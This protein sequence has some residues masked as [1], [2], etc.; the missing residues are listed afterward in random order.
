MIV[1]PKKVEM[2]Y[3]ARLTDDTQKNIDARFAR[4]QQAQ[5][6]SVMNLNEKSRKAGIRGFS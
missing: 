5:L 4:L 2:A 3:A 6:K 1:D